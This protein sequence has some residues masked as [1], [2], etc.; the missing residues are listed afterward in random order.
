V[1]RIY[2]ALRDAQRRSRR[3]GS[4]LREKES[5]R[6]QSPRVAAGVPLFVY[7]HLA[8]R[9]P[10][11]E[12]TATL[13]VSATGARL[14]LFSEVRC[15]QSLLLTNRVTLQELKCR[16]VRVVPGR[17]ASLEVG[18]ALVARSADLWQLSLPPFGHRPAR[19]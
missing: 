3:Q 6:R 4:T 10:F 13:D 8:G 2:E 15:G 18:V 19:S 17:N 9:K 14:L 11:H 16:V 5:E 7:G 12:E 1:S